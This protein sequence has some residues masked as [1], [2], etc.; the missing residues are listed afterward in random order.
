M[1]EEYLQK[2]TS[3]DGVTLALVQVYGLRGGLYAEVAKGGTVVRTKVSSPEAGRAVLNIARADPDQY[4]NPPE[5]EPEAEP[6]PVAAKS[7]KKK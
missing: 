6:A 2:S 1:S 5:P 4:L 7:K 3:G